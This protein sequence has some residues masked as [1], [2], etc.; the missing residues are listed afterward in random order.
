M[1]SAVNLAAQGASST[2]T[3][4]TDQTLATQ[5][6][7]I[8][9]QLVSLANTTVDGRAIFGGDQDQSAPYQY[10]AASLVTGVDSLTAQTSSR[11]IVDTQGQTVYQPLTAQQIFDPVDVNR[12]AHGE[13]Y[14]RRAAISLHRAS[15]EQPD[16]NCRTR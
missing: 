9:Q 8:Q 13:Q 3:A 1:Q 5:I 14:F 16:R 4:A 7:S 11:V 12:S 10:D 15:G 6:Q 2:S